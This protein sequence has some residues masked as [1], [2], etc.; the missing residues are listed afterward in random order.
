MKRVLCLLMDEIEVK[1]GLVFSKSTGEL[2]GFLDLG[3][4]NS[5]LKA[6]DQH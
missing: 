2:V 3:T 1:S 6:L 4:V 5:D